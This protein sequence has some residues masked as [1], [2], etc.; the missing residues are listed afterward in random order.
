MLAQPLQ[1]S[2]DDGLL[3]VKIARAFISAFTTTLDFLLVATESSSA[4]TELTS[5]VPSLLQDL[6]EVTNSMMIHA[7][8][9]RKRRGV[10][11]AKSAETPAVL[12]EPS[13]RAQRK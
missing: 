11:T 5:S 3:S 4:K 1:L 8:S 2:I 12:E 7:P 13:S 9:S 6:P 10:V